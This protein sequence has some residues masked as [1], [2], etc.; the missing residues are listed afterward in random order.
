[1]SDNITDIGINFYP[2]SNILHRCVNKQHNSVVSRTPRER[3]VVGLNPGHY[4]VHM[5]HFY[6]LHLETIF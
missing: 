6:F 4:S 2:I 1:M 3:R 5:V